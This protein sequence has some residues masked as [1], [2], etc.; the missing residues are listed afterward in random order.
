MRNYLTFWENSSR[1]CLQKKRST[2]H[3]L[4]TIF[5]PLIGFPFSVST[6]SNPIFPVFLKHYSHFARFYLSAQNEFF[7]ILRGYSFHGP[8]GARLRIELDWRT[9]QRTIWWQLC[10]LLCAL[11]ILHTYIQC[12]SEIRCCLPTHSRNQFDSHTAEPTISD[13]LNTIS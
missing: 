12:L 5:H 7:T 8:L 13:V 9:D 6:L 11:E 4:F 10:A 1:I 3:D 2:Q